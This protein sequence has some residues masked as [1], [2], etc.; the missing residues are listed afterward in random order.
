[1]MT[2]TRSDPCCRV[3]LLPR[4]PPGSSGAGLAEHS[5]RKAIC[6]FEVNRYKERMPDNCRKNA[7]QSTT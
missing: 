1:M 2:T 7:Q 5:V 6:F 4:A 3:I